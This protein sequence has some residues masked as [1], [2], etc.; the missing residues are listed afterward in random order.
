MPHYL[1]S[2]DEPGSPCVTGPWTRRKAQIEAKYTSWERE[3]RVV[4]AESK[5]EAVERYL[6]GEE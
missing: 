1:V 5:G 6:E 4:E 2:R 3:P